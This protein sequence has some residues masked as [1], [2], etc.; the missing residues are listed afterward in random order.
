MQGC[1][2]GTNRNPRHH[3]IEDPEEQFSRSDLLAPF[4]ISI[5]FTNTLTDGPTGWIKT[6]SIA[7]NPPVRTRKIALIS[8]RILRSITDPL[9]SKSIAVN[10][11]HHAITDHAILT[12]PSLR[13][14]FLGNHGDTQWVC[15]DRSPPTTHHPPPPTTRPPPTTHCYPPTTDSIAARAYRP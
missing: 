7:V 10:P 13:P 12:T 8:F 14:L 1:E 11:S 5:F 9:L 6:P 15:G 3:I 4:I 2:R